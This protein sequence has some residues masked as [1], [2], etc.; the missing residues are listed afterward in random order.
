MAAFKCRYCSELCAPSRKLLARH[1]RLV[2]SHEPGFHIGCCYS[3]CSRVFRNYRTYQNHLLSHDGDDEFGNVVEATITD[4]S[5]RIAEESEANNLE[6]PESP[7]TGIPCQYCRRH[8]IKHIQ[9]IL[10]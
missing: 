5:E 10:F 1:V 9:N 6:I 2:H 3:S 4:N 7:S 8:S